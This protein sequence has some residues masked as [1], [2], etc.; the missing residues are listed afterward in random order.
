MRETPVYMTFR[1]VLEPQM[2]ASDTQ[3]TF[4]GNNLDIIEQNLNQDVIDPKQNLW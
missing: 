1:A 2:Y 3:L 4:A